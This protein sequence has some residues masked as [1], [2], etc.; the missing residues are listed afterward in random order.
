[1]AHALAGRRGD[2]RDIGDDRL[3]H[4]R[5][6]VLGRGLLVGAADLAD[7]HDAAGRRVRLEELEAVDEVHAADRIAADAD[8]RRL[9]ETARRRLPDRLVGERARARDD[10]DRARLMDR[11]RHDADLAFARRDDPGAVRADEPAVV[12]AEHLLDA[13]HVE[14]GHALGDADDELEAGIGRLEDRVRGERRR[15][16]DHARRRLGLARRLADRIEDRQ[17]EMLAAAAAR[18][19]AGDDLRAVLEALLRVECALPAGDA[20]ADD[21]RLLADEDAHAAPPASETTFDAASFKSSAG[22]IDK[23]LSASICLPFS[24]FVPSSRTTTGT[25]T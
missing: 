21:L 10:A 2:A 15:H 11:A 12:V 23:P 8:A 24:T 6:D 3:R 5:R 4:V 18:R 13:H 1:M 7:H 17:A 22:T 14:H 19:D 16:V 9:T 20:L 25:S